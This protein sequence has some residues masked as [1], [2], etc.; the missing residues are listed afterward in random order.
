[1]LLHGFGTSSFVWRN[2]APEIALATTPKIFVNTCLGAVNWTYK[3][4]RP[5]GSHTPAELGR[6]M[7]DALLASV[8]P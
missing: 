2:I 5:T 6:D 3:W 4:F 8:T 1:M 7:A